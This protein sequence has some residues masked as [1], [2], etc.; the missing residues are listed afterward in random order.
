MIQNINRSISEVLRDF[1]SI[2]FNLEENDADFPCVT[3]IKEN[4]VTILIIS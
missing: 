2:M 1:H 3:I 4:K